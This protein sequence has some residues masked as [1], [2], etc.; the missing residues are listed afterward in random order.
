MSRSQRINYDLF[1]GHH[2]CGSFSL[3]GHCL[4][5]DQRNESNQTCRATS[6]TSDSFER[7]DWTDLVIDRRTDVE[8]MIFPAG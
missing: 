2:H 6:W 5:D 3:A 8:P 7:R 1:D 4:T